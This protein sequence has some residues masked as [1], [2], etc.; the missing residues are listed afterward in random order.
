[1]IHWFRKGLRLHDNPALIK[2][3][4]LSLPVYPIF[5]MDPHFA[6]PDVIGI[7][8]YSFVLESLRDLDNSL[9]TLGAFIFVLRQ[10]CVRLTIR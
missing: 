4:D 10:N 7:N 9:R 8:R 2:A 1:M 5:V 3:F 6:K